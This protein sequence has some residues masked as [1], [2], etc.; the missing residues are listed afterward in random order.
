VVIGSTLFDSE[1]AHPDYQEK[2]QSYQYNCC[3][4]QN[5]KPYVHPQV[6]T[7][8]AC[9]RSLFKADV[10]EEVIAWKVLLKKTETDVTQ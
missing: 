5:A 8:A 2:K 9:L 4:Y 10:I 6:P 1:N 3:M 7:Y